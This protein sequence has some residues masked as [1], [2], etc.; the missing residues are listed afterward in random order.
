MKTKSRP[1]M[2]KRIGTEISNEWKH[3]NI[4]QEALYSRTP[5][6]SIIYSKRHEWMH[7]S[8]T[9]KQTKQT[10]YRIQ[11]ITSTKQQKPTRPALMKQD[12]SSDKLV[13]RIYK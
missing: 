3:N 8:P 1:S 4:M 13:E 5:Y 12:L 11:H 9:K 2:S 7:F 10:N 6:H